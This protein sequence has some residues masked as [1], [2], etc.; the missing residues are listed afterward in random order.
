LA[1]L[2]RKGK[3]MEE[4]TKWIKGQVTG[5]P[6]ESEAVVKWV[7]TLSDG[8]TAVDQTGEWVEKPGERKPW[9]RLCEFAAKNKLH[10]TSLRLN[11]DGKTIHMPRDA[12][13]RFDMNETSMT[14]DYY[15][16]TY[17]VEGELGDG[18]ISNVEKFIDLAAHYKDF[19]VHYLQ[20]VTNTNV[21]WVLVTTG[22]GRMATSPHRKLHA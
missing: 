19:A 21:S 1:I 17:H 5:Q 13:D 22:Q 12:W 18:G 15:S 11:V 6:Q 7:A 2:I 14:P 16:L 20:N 10:L 4:A 8:T 9:V 3:V